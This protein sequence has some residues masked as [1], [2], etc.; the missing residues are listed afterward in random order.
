MTF[1]TRQSNTPVRCFCGAATFDAGAGVAPLA[2]VDDAS[3]K[4]R[5]LNIFIYLFIYLKKKGKT[6][7]SEFFFVQSKKKKKTTRPS[8][9]NR[10]VA[11]A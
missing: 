7:S 11:Y 2:G 5:N 6:K 9:K 1:K 3:G 4:R 10:V 8:T